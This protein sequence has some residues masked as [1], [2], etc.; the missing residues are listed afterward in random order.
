M[1]DFLDKQIAPPAS[2]TKFEDLCRSLFAA[3]WKDKLAK[4]HG[5]SGH[6]QSG[7]DVYGSP[8]DRKGEVH[9]VQCKGKGAPYRAKA[10]TTEVLK[11]LALA[12]TFV[13]KLGHW[14][15]ATTAPDD[16]K[17]Q[18]FVRT[19]SAKRVAEGKFPIDIIG[20]GTILG[21]MAEHP[22]VIETH[23]R[24]H[25]R[26]LSEVIDEIRELVASSSH[27]EA[28]GAASVAAEGS[29][30]QEVRFEGVRDLGPALMGRPLGP[31]DIH[32]CPEL[33]EAGVVFSELQQ[34][35]SSRLIGVASR[36]P[37]LIGSQ[38]RS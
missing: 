1:M 3:V 20:W 13:P 17:L 7:V 8:T 36:W 34:A 4:K 26:Q 21:L 37:V 6:A 29:E 31:S 19:L 10:T 16:A 25:G 35:F 2:W 15:F 27:A 5:R 9:G 38:S 28:K 24:E 32:A 14:T 18:A 30:W 12:E 11:E 33:P 23:Y 22:S